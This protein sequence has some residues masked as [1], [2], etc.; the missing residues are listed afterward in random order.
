MSSSNTPAQVGAVNVDSAWS[1]GINN[2]VWDTNKYPNASQMIANFHSMNVRVI[3]WATS[4]V[5]TDSPSYQEGFD[6]NYYL[7][8][9]RT[10]KWWYVSV[11]V[12]PS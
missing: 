7:N 3:C 4:L 9:G 11:R 10:I 2:F 1:T 6:N 5:D 8:N 12:V